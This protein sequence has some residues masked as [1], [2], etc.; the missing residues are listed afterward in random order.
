MSD[1][2]S[3]SPFAAA[4]DLTRLLANQDT[5]NRLLGAIQQAIVDLA[6]RNLAH[7][8]ASP[9]DPAGTGSA[10]GVMMGLA[11]SVTPVFNGV[12]LVIISGTIF[13]GSGVGDGANVQI[14]Y[15]TGAAPAN[16]AAATGTA[17]GGLV[18]YVASTVA[19][20]VPFSLNA[21]LTGLTVATAYWVDVT[22]AATTA[23]TANITDVSISISELQ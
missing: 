21:I 8:Q 10:A 19:G 6:V 5:A 1:F 16:G 2:S 23:G 11:A 18:K 3:G 20:K 9:A 13:N 17:A 12:V 4:L 14:R 22:L 15:G 7:T